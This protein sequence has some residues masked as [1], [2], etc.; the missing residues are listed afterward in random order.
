MCAQSLAAHGGSFSSV[1]LRSGCVLFRRFVFLCSLLTSTVGN[2]WLLLAGSTSEHVPH[3]AGCPDVVASH[4][5]SVL[6][7][8][9]HLRAYV[10]H[11]ICHVTL[12]IICWSH[13]T[14]SSWQTG[15]KSYLSLAPQSQVQSKC[16]VKLLKGLRKEKLGDALS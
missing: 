11:C 5:H 9:P 12:V 14:G 15:A 3:S 8:L 10:K 16:S 1:C 4:L 7:P 2:T 6:P 13:Q